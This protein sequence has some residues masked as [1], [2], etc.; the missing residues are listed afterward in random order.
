MIVALISGIVTVLLA[1]AMCAASAFSLAPVVLT[2]LLGE[3]QVKSAMGI[4]FVFQS[5]ATISSTFIVGELFMC[6][7]LRISS[8]SPIAVAS[9]SPQLVSLLISSLLPKYT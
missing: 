9:S 4:L 6:I 7:S 1:T 3:Q 8:I 2:E 5:A